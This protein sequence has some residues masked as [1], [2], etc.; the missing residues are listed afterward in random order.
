[1]ALEPDLLDPDDDLVILTSA[2]GSGKN[3]AGTLASALEAIDRE[4]VR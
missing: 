3:P 2:A 1:M 4:N